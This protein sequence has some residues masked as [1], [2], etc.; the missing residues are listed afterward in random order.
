MDYNNFVNRLS[1][2]IGISRGNKVSKWYVNVKLP[3]KFADDRQDFRKIN[4]NFGRDAFRLSAKIFKSN[5]GRA[6]ES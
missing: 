5:V 4:K 3:A 2:P 6:V 1:L